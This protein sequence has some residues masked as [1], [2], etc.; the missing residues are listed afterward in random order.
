MPTSKAEGTVAFP[1]RGRAY[2]FER[3]KDFAVAA[4]AQVKVRLCRKIAIFGCLCKSWGV[5]SSETAGGMWGMLRNWQALT[6]NYVRASCVQRWTK[7]LPRASF[8]C[9]LQACFVLICSCLDMLTSYVASGQHLSPLIPCICEH[10]HYK[11][12]SLSSGGCADPKRDT[13]SHKKAC[14]IRSSHVWNNLWVCADD[15]GETINQRRMPKAF[16][17]FKNNSVKPP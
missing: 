7:Q 12:W 9:P 8:F 2:L 5:A 1:T 4:L 11:F 14:Y 6:E 13:S 3:L 15:P 10:C 16:L 17:T